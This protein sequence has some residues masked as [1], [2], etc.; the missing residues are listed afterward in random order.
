MTPQSVQSHVVTRATRAVLAEL[1]VAG[2]AMV[3]LVDGLS[4]AYQELLGTPFIYDVETYLRAARGMTIFF[5]TA[6]R[7]PWHPFWLRLGLAWFGDVERA[8]RLVTVAQ[9]LLAGMALYGFCRAHLG[10]LT[11]VT[12][13]WLFAG[14]HTVHYYGVSGLRDPVYAAQLLLFFWFMFLPVGV[15]RAARTDVW[16]AVWGA[17]LYL[18]R[19]YG[20][21]QVACAAVWLL[22]QARAWRSPSRRDVLRRVGVV[23][24]ALLVTVALDRI[25]RGT[26]HV[27][28]DVIYWWAREKLNADPTPD[29]PRMTMLQ[30][31]MDGRT[32]WDVVERVV[33]NHGLFLRAYLPSFGHGWTLASP[34]LLVVGAALAVWKRREFVPVAVVLA[35]APAVFVLNVNMVPTA[36]GVDKRLVLQAY[37][38]ALPLMPW[39]LWT[40]CELALGVLSRRSPAL[41]PVHAWLVRWQRPGGPG[42][43]SDVDEGTPSS[44]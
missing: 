22:F 25:L 30:Y 42:R 19:V 27:G 37:L 26:N 40:L 17:V 16:A 23:L 33:R 5:D 32:V 1:V 2:L 29:M 15:P 13:L 10:V 3:L 8:A 31:I 21:L 39:S 14:N 36:F 34:T 24:T 9:T 12:T 28:N 20:L 11:A 41:A 18:T 38:L 7:E 6:E 4:Q 44:L 35:L 43:T